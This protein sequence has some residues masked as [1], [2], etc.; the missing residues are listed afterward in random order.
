MPEGFSVGGLEQANVVINKTFKQVEKLLAVGGLIKGFHGGE[1]LCQEI[2]IWVVE[3]VVFQGVLWEAGE[4][5]KPLCKVATCLGGGAEEGGA[6]GP[7]HL[8][9]SWDNKANFLGW[10]A[11]ELWEDMA[12]LLLLVSGDAHSP[13]PIFDVQFAEENGAIRGGP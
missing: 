10:L 13:E 12:E 6:G 11:W 5:P 1:V 7:S 3:G 2:G 9:C 8:E 4:E